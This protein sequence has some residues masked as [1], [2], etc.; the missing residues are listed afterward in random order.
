MTDS[1]LIKL[2]AKDI[3]TSKMNDFKLGNELAV[4]FKYGKN[5][6]EI[7][8]YV[9]LRQNDSVVDAYNLVSNFYERLSEQDY[10]TAFEMLS[11]DFFGELPLQEA[12]AKFT[13]SYGRLKYQ[14]RA[15]YSTPIQ[16]V[17]AKILNAG[18][19]EVTLIVNTGSVYS[20][21]SGYD[22]FVVRKVNDNWQIKS[23]TSNLSRVA[24]NAEKFSS[25]GSNKNEQSLFETGLKYWHSGRVDLANLYFNEVSSL[26][27][28]N[29]AVLDLLAQSNLKRF[30]LDTCL[31]NCSRALSINPADAEAHFLVA[32]T[33]FYGVNPR[34]V[35]K[36]L[37]E[38][39]RG[40]IADQDA[41]LIMRSAVLH[42]LGCDGEAFK[43]L[44]KQF[45]GKNL[46]YLHARSEVLNGLGRYEE[47]LVDSENALALSRDSEIL[48]KLLTD[49]A[50]SYSALKK[51][52]RAAAELNRALEISA[53]WTDESWVR[54]QMEKEHL[55][56]TR[57]SV[58]QKEEALL[59]VRDY[60]LVQMAKIEI[61][62]K[63]YKEALSFCSQV[64]SEQDE[65][66]IT[67]YLRAK[68]YFAMGKYAD[69]KSEV[70]SI[71]SSLRR[72]VWGDGLLFKALC[73]SKQGN[74]E[75]ARRTYQNAVD[76][77]GIFKVNEFG[78]VFPAAGDRPCNE[79]LKKEVELA[80]HAGL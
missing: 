28:R 7:S 6:A 78:D 25:P 75:E 68:T 64:N 11:S 77:V 63:R 36:E 18:E 80:L 72:I 61:A 1:G 20:E 14:S 66:I 15:P 70:D 56:P 51:F 8:S 79:E 2:Q 9:V 34:A 3:S 65:I 24:W 47:A 42:R 50:V 35:L 31:E 53:N 67:P 19:D 59:R 13:D 54:R 76:G 48:V 45:N 44:S 55:G 41:C 43:E 57:V 33:Y 10:R 17:E 12:L 71:L 16:N 39:R 22:R 29:V 38:V 32:K 69:A 58:R 73:Q 62:E 46:D 21:A 74:L 5:G 49:R 26:E 60:A 4:I 27:P 52:D 23:I 40:A 37:D 30:E